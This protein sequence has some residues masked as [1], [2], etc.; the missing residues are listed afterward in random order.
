[1]KGIIFTM[2]FYLLTCITCFANPFLTAVPME[3]NVEYYVLNVDGAD[4]YI[5]PSFDMN[6]LY[7]LG[8]F[9]QDK[10]YICE[11]RA[12]N[13]EGECPPVRFVINRKSNKN[14]I[15]FT[16]VKIPEEALKDPSYNERFIDEE[17][18][19]KVNISDIT[20][21]GDK[22]MLTPDGTAPLGRSGGNDACF[23]GASK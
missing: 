10:D 3:N 9:K 1:M 17:L 13:I 8:L 6:F 16:I 18:S 14:W 22:Q 4:E 5:P 7:E 2:L 15:F 21:T 11:L 12:G 19:L 23:I 20:I